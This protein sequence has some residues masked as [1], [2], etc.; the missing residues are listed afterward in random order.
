MSLVLLSSLVGFLFPME[1]RAAESNPMAA[2]RPATLPTTYDAIIEDAANRHGVSA[3]MVRA[4]VK[5]ESN[6]KADARSPKGALGLMQLLPS[7]ALELGATTLFD[8]HTNINAGTRHL[9]RLLDRYSGSAQLALAAYNAGHGAVEKYGRTIPPYPETEAYVKKVLAHMGSPYLTHP[10]M[11]QRAGVALTSPERNTSP[12]LQRIGSFIGTILTS[13]GSK[14]ARTD[15][16]PTPAGTAA[17]G[18]ASIV[19]GV[20]TN[21]GNVGH[22]EFP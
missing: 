8:P 14:S 6:F 11:P 1:L 17:L 2:A 21:I 4:V 16:P 18:P 3:A 7:T 9:K 22:K 5:V 10:P 20:W 13:G 15:S 19:G 12:Q